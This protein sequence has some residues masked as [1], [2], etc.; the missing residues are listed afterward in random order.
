MESLHSLDRSPYRCP[1]ARE[2]RKARRAIRC[3][4][5]GKRRDVYRILFEVDETKRVVWI[6]H[7]RHSARRDLNSKDIV[8]VLSPAR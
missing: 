3:L 7:I 8:N 1:L 2:S 6:L 5:F 4:L